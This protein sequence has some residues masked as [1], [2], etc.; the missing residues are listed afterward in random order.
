MLQME[1]PGC[2]DSWKLQN[3]LTG[4]WLGVRLGW[5]L[6][7]WVFLHASLGF[8]LYISS[9]VSSW[10]GSYSPK[11][12]SN[13][14]PPKRTVPKMQVYMIKPLFAPRLLM[15]HKQRQSWSQ[16]QIQPKGLH[17]ASEYWEECVTGAGITVCHNF[18]LLPSP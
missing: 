13:L 2:W 7:I 3:G 17:V 9:V 15:S 16:T 11:A 4:H 10:H 8:F 5:W 14:K 18:S 6:E 12:P 1:E